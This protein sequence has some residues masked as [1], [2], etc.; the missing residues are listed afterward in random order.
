[1]IFNIRYN[2]MD[3]YM[4][5]LLRY[6]PMNIYMIYVDLLDLIWVASSKLQYHME[7]HAC[8]LFRN[9]LWRF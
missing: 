4:E 8:F 7:I 2:P 3:I 9:D 5:M 6:H 1:M